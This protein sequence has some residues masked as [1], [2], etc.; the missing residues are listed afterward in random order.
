MYAQPQPG[1]PQPES[2][3]LDYITPQ[4][5]YHD[6]GHQQPEYQEIGYSQGGFAAPSNMLNTQRANQIAIQ[7]QQQT[8]QQR[9]NLGQRPS[10]QSQKYP[11]S[12]Q[13]SRK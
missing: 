12:G 7:T 8:Q 3:E 4:P 9:Q 6:P 10:Y 1:Y 5:E 13:G 11:A 2:Q